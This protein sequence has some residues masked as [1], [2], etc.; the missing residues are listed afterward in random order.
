MKDEFEAFIK[1]KLEEGVAPSL[2]SLSVI[3]HAAKENLSARSIFYRNKF[4]FSG[5]LAAALAAIIALTVIFR[6]EAADSREMA[7]ATKSTSI[8]HFNNVT[9]EIIGLLSVNDVESQEFDQISPDIDRLLSWQDAPYNE[10]VY[11][12][13]SYYGL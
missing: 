7:R 11:G 2:S 12:R 6:F 1:N 13:S 5:L 3:K 8:L 9:M 10:I 4:I